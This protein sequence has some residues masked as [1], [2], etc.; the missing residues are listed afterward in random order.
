MSAYYL[1]MRKRAS[2]KPQITTAKATK[3]VSE[4]RV[5]RAFGILTLSGST[6]QTIV[7]LRGRPDAIKPRPRRKRP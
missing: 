5:Q 6:D 7:K 4:D 2:E 3:A 1:F